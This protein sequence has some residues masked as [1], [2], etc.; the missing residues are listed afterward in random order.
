[1]NTE[2]IEIIDD[3][4]IKTSEIIKQLSE[5]FKVYNY[6]ERFNK[7]NIDDIF[8]P[9]AETT[10]RK[11]KFLQNADLENAGKSADELDK[12]KQITLRERLLFEMEYFMRTNCHLDAQMSQTLCAGSRDLEGKT[13]RVWW[14]GELNIYAVGSFEK[15][16]YNPDGHYIYLASR[17]AV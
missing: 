6:Y 17:T 7:G 10:K 2:F 9:P 4:K 15:A 8:P 3:N 13:P 14:D 16:G 5:K 11:F 1:M 12:D